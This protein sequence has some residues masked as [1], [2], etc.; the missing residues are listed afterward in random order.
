MIATDGGYSGGDQGIVTVGGGSTTSAGVDPYTTYG[1][2]NGQPSPNPSPSTA[3]GTFSGAPIGGKGGAAIGGKG[4]APTPPP[5]RYTA[6]TQY[7]Q[8]FQQQFM[9]P[10][11]QRF[12]MPSPGYGSR[13]PNLGGGVAAPFNPE[14]G[15]SQ[16]DRSYMDQMRQQKAAMGNRELSPE[17]KRMRENMTGFTSDE[18]QPQPQLQQ[19]YQPRFQPQPQQYF[20]PQQYQQDPYMN[21]MRNQQQA[22]Q[23]RFMQ[24]NSLQQYQT[25]QQQQQRVYQQQA[26]QAAQ[27]AAPQAATQDYSYNQIQF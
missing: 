27:Q 19:Q 17:A 9:P 8:P 7:Q 12:S 22:L 11:Q 4:G 15:V 1:G 20:R 13:G 18:F 2:T 3:G 25:A 26:Q 14:Q 24:Q 16:Y 10:Q 5:A 23:Q 6:Q 21:A